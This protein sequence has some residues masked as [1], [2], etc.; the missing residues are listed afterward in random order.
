MSETSSELGSGGRKRTVAHLVDRLAQRTSADRLSLLSHLSIGRT[1]CKLRDA[2]LAGEEVSKKA[3][4]SLLCAGISLYRRH[5]LGDREEQDEDSAET[6]A[7][8]KQS[9]TLV[10]VLLAAIEG[11]SND[12]TD[13]DVV[14]GKV[15]AASDATL[16]HVLRLPRRKRKAAEAEAEAEGEES[17]DAAAWTR[18]LAISS[19]ELTMCVLRYVSCTIGKE[20]DKEHEQLADVF[21]RN[22]AACMAHGLLLKNGAHDYVS[23]RSQSTS[24]IPRDKRLLAIAQAGESEAGQS[25]LRDMLLSF[26]LPARTVGVR[27]HLLMSRAAS[28]AAGVDHADAVNQ[29]HSVA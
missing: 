11:R 28:T 12:S 3:A 29:A 10:F 18:A 26:L 20:K 17:E 27:R 22:S 14:H 25:V 15:T 13:L 21:F 23:L 8:I 9:A 16:R 7:L 19:G 5:T 4:M 1:L 2:I 24:D 6:S